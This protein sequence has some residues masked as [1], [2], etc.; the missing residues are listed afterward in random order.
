MTGFATAQGQTPLGFMAVELRGVNSRFLDLTLRLSD[1]FRA[2]EA[3]VRVG[4]QARQVR[5]PRKPQARRHVE[6]WH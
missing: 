3:M 2:T 5:V 6:L 1:E 4:R